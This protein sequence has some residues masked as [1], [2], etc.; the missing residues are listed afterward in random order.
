MVRRIN[1]NQ[2]NQ[3]IMRQ[4]QNYS[5]AIQEKA[6]EKAKEVG[7]SG[8]NRLRNTSPER[9]GSYKS[10]WRLK[11]VG[12]G[13]VIH[14]ATNYQLTHLLEKSHLQRDGSMSTPQ[15]HIRPVEQQVIREYVNEVRR[16]IEN[17]S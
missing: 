12:K 4:L 11:K 1:P 15:V 14:N 5:E 10:G 7:Q 13:Y 2:L 16:V 9:T 3:E 17:E 8:V 6:T